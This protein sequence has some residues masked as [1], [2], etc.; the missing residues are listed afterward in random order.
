M[1]KKHED[2]TQIIEIVAFK[3]ETLFSLEGE[4]ITLRGFKAVMKCSRSWVSQR[5]VEDVSLGFYDHIARRL[6]IPSK[7][8]WSMG[9]IDQEGWDEINDGNDPEEWTNPLEPGS[10]HFNIT[11][12]NSIPQKNDDGEPSIDNLISERR[13]DLA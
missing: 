11:L 3:Q 12:L 7:Q 5:V 13:T 8:W 6:T 4:P 1:L 10:F 2:K 9:V